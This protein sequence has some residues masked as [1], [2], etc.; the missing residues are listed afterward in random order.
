MPG[1]GKETL[2]DQNQLYRCTSDIPRTGPQNIGFRDRASIAPLVPGPWSPV[3][4]LR[5]VGRTSGSRY[6]ELPTT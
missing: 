1:L 6:S 3:P 5:M 2:N 4:G